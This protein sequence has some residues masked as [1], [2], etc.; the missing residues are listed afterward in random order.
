VIVYQSAHDEY[1]AVFRPSH[2]ED[3]AFTS[4]PSASLLQVSVAVTVTL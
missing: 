3:R 4:L 1:V 2:P